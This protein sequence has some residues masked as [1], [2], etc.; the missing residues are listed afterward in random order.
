MEKGPMKDIYFDRRCL[1]EVREKLDA[2]EFLRNPQRRTQLR[3]LAI[4]ESVP[5][6]ASLCN[7]IDDYLIVIR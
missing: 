2:R 5:Q 1:Y 4:E 6:L 3:L 7:Q